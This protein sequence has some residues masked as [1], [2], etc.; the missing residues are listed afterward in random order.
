[1]RGNLRNFKLPNNSSSTV[2]ANDW[3]NVSFTSISSVLLSDLSLLPEPGLPFNP[4]LL[5]ELGLLLSLDL[6][7]IDVSSLIARVCCLFQI[8]EIFGTF[9]NQALK[10]QNVWEPSP[11]EYLRT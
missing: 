2:N 8:L 10:L 6:M 4:G 11:I 5:P 1:M 3:G 7:P 9:E